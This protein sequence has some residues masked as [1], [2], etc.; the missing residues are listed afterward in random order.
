MYIEYEHILCWSMKKINIYVY[1]YD[2]DL[3]FFSFGFR[4]E[5]AKQL[6]H[7]CFS[8]VLVLNYLGVSLVSTIMMIF[9]TQHS[10]LNITIPERVSQKLY[11]Y[12]G[13]CK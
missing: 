6:E 7:K 10:F 2:I 5:I 12:F 8:L 4:S 1:M 9:F 11:I 13:C 3:I